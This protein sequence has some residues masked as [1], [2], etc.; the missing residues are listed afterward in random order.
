VFFPFRELPRCW[1]MSSPKP[2]HGTLEPDPAE[3]RVR[4]TITR[5]REQG[6]SLRQIAT[7]LN[8]ERRYT[9]TRAP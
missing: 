3:Q 1:A 4:R 8:T 2:K 9:C 5:L 7:S 6:R